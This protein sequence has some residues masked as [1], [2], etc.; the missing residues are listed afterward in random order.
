MILPWILGFL[1]GVFVGPIGLAALTVYYVLVVSLGIWMLVV[2]LGRLN[3]W[4][5]TVWFVGFI[6]VN[7][8][9]HWQQVK[10]GHI[11]PGEQ[12]LI[13]GVSNSYLLGWV[14]VRAVSQLSAPLTII[15]SI[16]VISIIVGVHALIDGLTKRNAAI[17]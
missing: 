3:G 12:V 14:F 7:M 17:G 2:L 6:G 11:L 16:V 9:L 10:Q 4:L 13:E 15:L 5:S 1:T 8:Y